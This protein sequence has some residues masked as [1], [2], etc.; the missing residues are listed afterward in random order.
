MSLYLEGLLAPV[1]DEIE[2][3]GLPVTGEL[4]P[5]LAGRYFRNGPNPLP[6][7][8]PGHWFAGHGMI[9]G[10]RIADGRAEWYRNRWVQTRRLA[11]DDYLT[12]T[13]PDRKAVT[14]NTNVIRHADKIYA[15]VEAGFPYELTPELDT[16]GPCDFGGR[17]TTSMTAHPKQDPVTGELHFFGYSVFPP[18]LTYHRLDARG[19]LVESRE[20]AV[21]GPTMMHDF[22]IT[23]N[24]VIWLDLPVTFDAERIGK[25]LAFDW[26]DSYGAR[27][28]VMPRGG[29]V[30]WFDVDPCYVFHVGNAHE[31]QGRI[32]LD[33]VRYTRDKFTST[34]REI[35]GTTNLTDFAVGTSLYRWIL[36]PATGKATEEMRDERNVEFPSF[37]EDRLGRPSRFLY[38]VTETA[39]VKY[40]TDTG[41]NEIK[42]LGKAPGE[43]EFVHK[44]NAK[45]EDD[46]WLMSIVTELDGS[47]SELLVLDA[48]TLEFAAS[49]RLPR[50][51]PTGFHGNW[52]PDA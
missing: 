46:G 13:G 21:P 42:E 32:V 30:Q 44:Q 25:G 15:L 26:S 36:D 4:P 48:R 39:I 40:D 5:E 31:D 38:T 6:G 18:F 49:V 28:G 51:V 24:H 8:D 10:V 19:E 35:S 50:R 52:L 45:G 7:Q 34:W 11:G 37:N 14:A 22:A 23:E 17:L 1:D 12:E 2:A 20:I 9:H 3:V 16:V 47:G 27:I 43:A 29:D 33:A 41:G